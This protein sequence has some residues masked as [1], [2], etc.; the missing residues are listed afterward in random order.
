M[1][2]MLGFQVRH[3]HNMGHIRNGVIWSLYGGEALK[4]KNPKDYFS[5]QRD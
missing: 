4:L 5:A 2:R 1:I 3:S